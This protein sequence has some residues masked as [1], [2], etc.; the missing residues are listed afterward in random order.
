MNPPAVSVIVAAYNATAT[1]EDCIDSLRAQTLNNLEII[2]ADDCSTDGTAALADRIAQGEPRLRVVRCA[3]NG[4]PAAARN[5][6]LDHARGDWVAIVDSDDTI[7]PE[8]LAA[9]I[10]AAGTAGTDIAFDDMYY[11]VPGDQAGGVRYL[12]DAYAGRGAAMETYIASHRR[13]GAA[14]NMGFLKPVIRRAALG[15]VRYDP[16]LKIGEDTM[17][18]LRLMAQGAMACLVPRAMYRYHRHGGSISAR[19]D[20]ASIRAIN[21]AYRAFLADPA[22]LLSAESRRLLQLLVADNNRRIAGKD[23]ADHVARGRLIAAGLPLMRQPGLIMATGRELASRL[24]Q[25]WRRR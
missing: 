4:G 6:A 9:M 15:A 23:I 3:R 10:E 2:V 24:K 5:A 8:R 11:I 21:D 17:L 18:V 22:A 25:G 20:A 7:L 16:G 12:G 13:G 14:P 1:L 19:Q